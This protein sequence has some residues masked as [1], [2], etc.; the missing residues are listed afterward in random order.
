VAAKRRREVEE[1]DLPADLD[2][3]PD[4]ALRTGDV[5]EAVRAGSG[6]QVPDAVYDV[7]ITESVL[8]GVDLRGRRLAGLR[9]M[10][11]RFESCD[12]A[13]A[14]LEGASLT[15]VAFVRCRMT[16]T[17]LSGAEL[18]DV[19]ITG[20]TADLLALRMATANG[21]AIT[22][23]SLREADFYEATLEA[24]RISGCDLTSADVTRVTVP[25]LDLRGSRLEAL[26]GPSALRGAVISEDQLFGLAGALAAEAGITVDAG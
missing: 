18:Q 11:V 20:G 15:R 2:A 8:E 22:D 1:P 7:V 24:S 10:D 5:L 16:G 19:Q 23:T 25:E 14:V 6:L 3:L 13:G 21:F 26:I 17:V 12:L 9:C 4:G